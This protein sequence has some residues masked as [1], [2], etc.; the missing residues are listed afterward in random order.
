MPDLGASQGAKLLLAKKLYVPPPRAHLVRRTRLIE[1][2]DD[3]MSRALTLI[4]APTGFGKT[5][6]VADWIKQTRAPVAWVSLDRN[7]DDLAR[8][9]AAHSDCGALAVLDQVRRDDHPARVIDDF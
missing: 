8:Q 5:T 7:D 4:S 3:S 6:L 9:L 1:R 2:L